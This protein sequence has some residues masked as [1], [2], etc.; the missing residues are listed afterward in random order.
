MK[1]IGVLICMMCAVSMW[2]GVSDMDSDAPQSFQLVCPKNVVLDCDDDLSNLSKW[3]D[4]YVLKDYKRISA[5]HPK[6][7]DERNSCGIG[8]ITRTWRVEDSHWKWH[9]C[10]QII[11][12][13]G[14]GG[15]GYHDITWPENWTIDTCDID[16]HPGN[17]PYPYSYP[18]FNK[19][20]CAHPAYNYKD[21][22]FEFSPTCTKVLRRWKVLDWCQYKPGG[23]KGI[24]EHVQVIKIEKGKGR[25][26][27]ECPKDTTILTSNCDSADVVLEDLIAISSCGDTLEVKHNSKFADYPFGNASGK[28]PVGKHV[29]TYYVEYGC[30]RELKCKQTIHVI[31]NKPPTPYC[32]N[33]IIT[34]LMPI[35][36][37]NDGTIDDGM[38]EV[39]A[40]DLN[41]GS[42]HACDPH[43]R[44]TYSFSSDTSD[45]VINFTCQNLGDNE[46]EIWVT[47]EYGNQTYCITV[48]TV[49]NNNPRLTHCEPDSLKGGVISGS[50][51]MYNGM[52]INNA[53][54]NGMGYQAGYTISVYD[55]TLMVQGRP[56]VITRQ[57]TL[58][59]DLPL[60]MSSS[61]SGAYLFKRLPMEKD[62]EIMVEKLDH[63][64]NGVDIWDYYTLTSHLDGWW[65]IND[66]L[67]L[68][69]ADINNDQKVNIFDAQQLISAILYPNTGSDFESWR[70]YA[71]EMVE[72]YVTQNTTMPTSSPVMIRHLEDKYNEI[73]WTGI[74][75]G[76]LDYSVDPS[77]LAPRQTSVLRGGLQGVWEKVSGQT[78]QLMLNDDVVAGDV[79]VDFGGHTPDQVT[80]QGSVFGQNTEQ[81]Y[82]VVWTQNADAEKIVVF[83]FEDEGHSIKCQTLDDNVV[84]DRA[85]RASSLSIQ[86]KDMDDQTGD[87]VLSVFPNP[88]K[89]YIQIEWWSQIEESVLIEIYNLVGQQMLSA[90]KGVVNNGIQV[91]HQNVEDLL[92]GQTYIF[93]LKQGEKTYTGSFIK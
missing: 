47:D 89:D 27:I 2:G 8:I 48:V 57:D 30:S 44:L 36:T 26:Y 41:A 21:E 42:F 40:S 64:L 63:P 83:T 72:D 43:R 55:D 34:T 49:Q 66:P 50:I 54:I 88:A 59:T 79:Y 68:L 61:T 4:A 17:L 92:E 87:K 37:N 51:S 56:V 12:V 9:T 19:K 85:G 39:W 91:I 14:G 82:R 35:D 22:V 78:Y 11:E 13:K 29:I 16:I 69:A 86:N 46:V 7:V 31:S 71:K 65:K 5:G 81:G 20:K 32:K 45:T 53:Q 74:K 10:T 62:Y 38:R 84:Y 60:H 73:M 80:V 1:T 90:D 33:G 77:G 70:F 23:N 24:W 18:R 76:D 25:P 67:A 93:T 3:G 15:F 28:Y 75:V 58:W 52:A 6:V